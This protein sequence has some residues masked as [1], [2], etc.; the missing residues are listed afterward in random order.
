VRPLRSVRRRLKSGPPPA[1]NAISEALRARVESVELEAERIELAILEELAAR[2]YTRG[3]NSVGKSLENLE[4]A[5][6]HFSG[7]VSAEALG[8]IRVIQKGLNMHIAVAAPE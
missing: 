1:P 3:L 6:R 7:E 5:L 4:L 8:L 2:A